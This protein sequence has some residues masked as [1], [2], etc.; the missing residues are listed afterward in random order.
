MKMSNSSYA[1]IKPVDIITFWFL[2]RVKQQWFKSTPALDNEIRDK[3]SLLWKQAAAGELDAWT[4][5]AAGCL[6]LA[7][8]LD[9]FPLNMFRGQAKSFST[10]KKA[11]KIT[12]A[13]ISKG[14]DK[15]LTK[16]QKAFL[17]MPLM[18]SENLSDQNQAVTLFARAGLESNQRFAEHHQSL[19]QRFGRFPHR[20]MALGRE[21]SE[22][23]ITYLKSKQ[24]FLG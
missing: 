5:S 22:K 7:I 17:Y 3:Y 21:S 24:A 11:I 23:E 8:V 16:Q 15:D 9:Q 13:A 2:Q 14:L 6:S 19:I 20:N 4:N 1:A 10:E 12:K 18:H